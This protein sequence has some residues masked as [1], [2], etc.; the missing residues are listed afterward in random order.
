M[1]CGRTLRSKWRGINL[2]KMDFG[3][4][5]KQL[6]R[7]GPVE[8]LETWRTSKPIW[9]KSWWRVLSLEGN[10]LNVFQL[11]Q[12]QG[13]NKAFQRKLIWLECPS[14]DEWIK[15]WYIITMKYYSAIKKEQNNAIC[16]H[17][18]ATRDY[19]T[20]WSKSER[21]GQRPYD[22]TYTWNLK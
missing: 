10:W 17:M 4:T 3:Q 21:E 9:W 1:L 22:I 19:H 11:H 2:I 6:H 7:Q 14:T 20:K 15:M 13:E 12:R 8:N 5:E 16:S 18:V